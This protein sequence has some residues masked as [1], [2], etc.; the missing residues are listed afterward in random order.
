[1]KKLLSKVTAII[2]FA[3][4]VYV[5]VFSTYTFGILG[6]VVFFAVLE[7][8]NKI[9]GGRLNRY[10]T[11]VVT[12]DGI[13][14]QHNPLFIF[15]YADMEKMLRFTKDAIEKL[16]Q[17]YPDK[18]VFAYT[19]TLAVL[20]KR[21]EIPDDVWSPNFWGRVSSYHLVLTNVRNWRRLQF[22]RFFRK[23]D[24]GVARK[25]ALRTP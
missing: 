16:S 20:A 24:N 6:P 25:V 3:L 19:V 12:K 22:V 15:Y 23:I 17:K 1:M 21:K 7:V 9:R 4:L 5:I 8:I 2:L 13:E 10:F 18:K 14:L 11:Y